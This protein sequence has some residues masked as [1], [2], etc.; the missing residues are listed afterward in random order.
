MSQLSSWPGERQPSDR[1]VE[2]GI[3][4]LDSEFLSQYKSTLLRSAAGSENEPLMN[5][6]LDALVSLKALESWLPMLRGSIQAPPVGEFTYPL[7]LLYD[8]PQ[9]PSEDVISELQRS[10]ASKFGAH[11]LLNTLPVPLS[12][13]GAVV[14]FFRL[15]LACLARAAASSPGPPKTPDVMRDLY[16]AGARL[17]NVM[18]EVDN[19]EA[20]TLEG[21]LSVSLLFLLVNFGDEYSRL[22]LPA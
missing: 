3:E 12:S 14:P 13:Q 8:F 19:R 20:R 6:R 1:D 18:V 9:L 11:P 22:K 17:W 2:L 4:S 16:F 21:V 7:S 15:S 10:F 5:M